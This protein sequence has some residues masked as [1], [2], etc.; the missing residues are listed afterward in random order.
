MS[1]G[2]QRRWMQRP[3]LAEGERRAKI[4]RVGTGLLAGSVRWQNFEAPHDRETSAGA[5]AVAADTAAVA[6]TGRLCCTIAPDAD[7]RR[8]THVA[9]RGHC[10]VREV[11]LDFTR[12]R[13]VSLPSGTRLGPYEVLGPLGAGG[14]GEVYRALDTRLNRRIAIK[15]L[16]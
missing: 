11:R 9:P 3:W 2:R 15:V 13:P 1:R 10:C 14:M 16:P 5:G 6:L 4:S 7:G 8:H 12:G